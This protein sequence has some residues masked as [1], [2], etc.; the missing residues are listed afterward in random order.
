MQTHLSLDSLFSVIRVAL[1]FLA[2]LGQGGTFLE[3]KFMP[4]FWTDKGRAKNSF[5]IIDSQ[6]PLTQNDT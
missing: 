3:G 6:L 4:Y 5:S 2:E 1:F